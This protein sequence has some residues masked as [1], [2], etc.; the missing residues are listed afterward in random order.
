MK[1]TTQMSPEATRGLLAL[2]AAD[3]KA[4]KAPAPSDLVA[5][6]QVQEHLAANNQ[7]VDAAQAALSKLGLSMIDAKLGGVPVIDVRPRGWDTAD[8]RLII[9]VHGGAFTIN[10]ARSTVAN[11][12]RLAAKSG[13]RVISVDYT[14]A[15][16]ANW[17][18]IQDEVLS[19]FNDLR[20]Q[21]KPDVQD[22]DHRSVH[23]RHR[24]ER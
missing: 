21:G 3:F 13:I 2:I 6:C 19:V 16:A 12:G 18:I 1:M 24:A 17:K 22:G 7:R 23:N 15:P 11:A 8:R 14:L 4:T 20:K 10:S 5:W 9:Y